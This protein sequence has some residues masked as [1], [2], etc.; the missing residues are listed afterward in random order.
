VLLIV[1]NWQLPRGN[2]EAT[3]CEKCTE[4]DTKIEHYQYLSRMVTDQLTVDGIQKLV[5]QMKAEKVALHPE[6]QR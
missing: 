3:M 6:L 1:S 4:I 2:A 5:E